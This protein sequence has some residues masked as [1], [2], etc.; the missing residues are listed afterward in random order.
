MTY[1]HSQIGLSGQAAF[2]SVSL[3]FKHFLVYYV[4]Y[5]AVFFIY[6]PTDVTKQKVLKIEF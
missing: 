5:G 2:N 6:W 4:F 3:S 1:N